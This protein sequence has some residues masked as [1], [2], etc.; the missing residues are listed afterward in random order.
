[1]TTDTSQPQNIEI[2]SN[3]TPTQLV[4]SLGRQSHKRRIEAAVALGQVS[5]FGNHNIREVNI[6]CSPEHARNIIQ[7]MEKAN[8]FEQ[9]QFA[10]FSCSGS[11]DV[12]LVQRSLNNKS[13]AIQQQAV[14]IIPS[15]LRALSSEESDSF[16]KMNE[17]EV[18]KQCV[19][20]IFFVM[21]YDHLLSIIYFAET[22]H[23][24]L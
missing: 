16:G 3:I 21:F 12:G 10:L 7:C 9:N 14:H 13:H 24:F 15:V 4:E 1:M 11:K 17:E 6:M 8:D 5:R 22:I 2:A 20:Y 23:N 19:S 18:V